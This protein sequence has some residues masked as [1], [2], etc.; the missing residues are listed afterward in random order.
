MEIVLCLQIVTSGI[1]MIFN[2]V[3]INQNRDGGL[4]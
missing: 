1:S 2:R 3:E 4:G